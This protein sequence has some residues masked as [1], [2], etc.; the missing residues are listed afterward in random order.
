MLFCIGFNV[1]TLEYK[2]LKLT[3]WDVGG[4]TTIRKLWEYYFSGTKVN[5]QLLVKLLE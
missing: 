5:I 3:V 1:E 2:N 4:Q